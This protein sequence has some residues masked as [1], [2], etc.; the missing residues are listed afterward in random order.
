MLEKYE[1]FNDFIKSLKEDQLNYG[2][3]IL[4]NED[5]EN[6][7]KLT[8]EKI[9]VV[10]KENEKYKKLMNEKNEDKNSSIIFFKRNI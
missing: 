8:E 7:Q 1:S 6:M 10:Q 4:Y 2:I 3:D 5:N 9:E